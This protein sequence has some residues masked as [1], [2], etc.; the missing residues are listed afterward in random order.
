V[1][2][3]R[4]RRSPG[5]RATRPRRR[6]TD[7]VEDIA[8]WLLTAAGAFLL[9]FAAQL[10]ATVHAS[11]AQ[12]GVE[13]AAVPVEAV[14]T[15][16][17]PVATGPMNA[18]LLVRAP[19]R[20]TGGDG[21][22]ATGPVPAGSGARAGTAVTIWLDPA[23]RPAPPPVDPGVQGWISAA[24]VVVVGGVLLGTAWIGVRGLTGRINSARWER[25]W[26]EVGPDWS[27]TVR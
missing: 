18:A 1:T 23:G 27:R 15:D 2:T 21:L 10:G 9:A 12:R 16:D 22:P 5:G 20:W 11:A 24:G 25:E 14:L 26:A 19:A 17:A 8:V 6:G 3:G 13:S 7:L 4:P